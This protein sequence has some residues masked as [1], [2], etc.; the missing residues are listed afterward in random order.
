MPSDRAASAP[1]Q[2]RHLRP[3]LRPSPS[4]NTSPPPASGL[5]TA[6]VGILGAP[7]LAAALRRMSFR[8]IGGTQDLAA[9]ASLI[10]DA[11]PSIAVLVPGLVDDPIRHEVAT[12]R[13]ETSRVVILSP[14]PGFTYIKGTEG[15]LPGSTMAQV[16]R[17]A[18]LPETDGTAE[19][20]IGA[21]GDLDDSASRTAQRS[22][23][24]APPP[25]HH[26]PPKRDRPDTTPEEPEAPR[27]VT[28]LRPPAEPQSTPP[29]RSTPS[30]PQPSTASAHAPGDVWKLPDGR[31]AQMNQ[32]GKVFVLNAAGDGWEALA[33]PDPEPRP[34]PALPPLPLEPESSPSSVEQRADTE[35]WH[36]L[37]GEPAP[38]VSVMGTKGGIQK[39]TTSLQLAQRAAKAG[40]RVVYVDL[41][42]SQGGGRVIL[43]Q[44]MRTDLPSVYDVGIA[45]RPDPSL[46][47]V[48]P[49][50]LNEGR[51]QKYDKIEFAVALAPPPTLPKNRARKASASV[52]RSV[53]AHAREI[54][55]L[56]VVDTRTLEQDDTTDLIDSVVEPGLRNQGWWGLFLAPAENAEGASLLDTRLNRFLNEGVRSSRLMYAVTQYRDELEEALT[57]FEKQFRRAAYPIGEIYENPEIRTALNSSRFCETAPEVAPVLDA[58]LLRVTNNPTFDVQH[59]SPGKKSGM[60]GLFGKK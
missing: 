49:P 12:K 60:F 40:L 31:T 18:G 20:I 46:A 48:A 26:A 5:D 41:N 28:P 36:R 57:T 52:Y 22:D 17:A 39:T 11:E 51:S 38:V 10:A 16:L 53:I 24:A 23:R 13:S 33:E 2:M 3:R 59:S 54:A 8:V 50:K 42:R 25:V 43:H 45:P 14:L 35:S 7:R 9:D 37:H 58:V 15:F 1:D 4:V 34:A 32:Y 27:K 44:A 47:I 56:V 55:D 21:D 6:T 29:G 30:A 19:M